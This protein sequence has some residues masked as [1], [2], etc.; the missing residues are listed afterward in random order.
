MYKRQALEYRIRPVWFSFCNYRSELQNSKS[1]PFRW[2]SFW[3]K[4]CTFREITARFCSSIV[5]LK[6]PEKFRFPNI[7]RMRQRLV[8]RSIHARTLSLGASFRLPIQSVGKS[9]RFIRWCAPARE[10]SSIA[11]SCWGFSTPLQIHLRC[12]INLFQYVNSLPFLLRSILW[13]AL[14]KG[15]IKTLVLSIFL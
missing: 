10:M 7:L 4:K 12:I 1:A 2:F 3:W 14:C 15:C 8:W 6:R 9:A 11:V 13:C 5:C